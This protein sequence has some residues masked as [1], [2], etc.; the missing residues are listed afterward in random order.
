MRYRKLGTLVNVYKDSCQISHG[1]C[2][3]NFSFNTMTRNNH[4]GIGLMKRYLL[5]SLLIVS[6]SA[7][8]DFD[9]GVEC[10]EA[11]DYACALKEFMVEAD[12]GDASA[13]FN[14]GGMYRQGFGV[15]QDYAEAVKWYRLAA[16]QGHAI[17]Q[18]NM[19]VM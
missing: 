12:Q 11:N 1:P 4:P 15:K 13:Q 5:L 8:A 17:A 18:N 6:A 7:H 9:K 19:G 14:L 3:K 2:S 16:D 10:Y